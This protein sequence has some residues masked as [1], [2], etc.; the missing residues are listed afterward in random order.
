MPN[1][2]ADEQSEQGQFNRQS[3]SFFCFLNLL[4]S[5]IF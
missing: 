3:R 5:E 2:F 1:G 4:T